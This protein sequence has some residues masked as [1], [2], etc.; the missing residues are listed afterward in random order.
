MACFWQRISVSVIFALARYR[1]VK[2]VHSSSEVVLRTT[3]HMVI[4]PDS[5]P[6]SKVIALH[7]TVWYIR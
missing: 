3:K 5:G 1:L 2:I 6:S 4:Y 7:P